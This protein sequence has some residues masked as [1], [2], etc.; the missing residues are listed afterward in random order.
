MIAIVRYILYYV[1]D[2]YKGVVYIVS[3]YLA[4][5]C[6]DRLV[7]STLL[8]GRSAVYY[9]FIG[10]GLVL[11]PV[12]TCRGVVLNVISVVNIAIVYI[13]CIICVIIDA[14]F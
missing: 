7:N 13:I 2:I 11:F 14:G 12:V 9:I 10:I 8:C 3:A 5:Q 6:L 1:K 4:A